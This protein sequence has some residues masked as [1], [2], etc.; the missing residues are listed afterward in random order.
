MCWPNS[1][2]TFPADTVGQV[3]LGWGTGCCGPCR[4]TCLNV[5]RPP[6]RAQG[7]GRGSYPGWARAGA[8]RFSRQG[9]RAGRGLLSRRICPLLLG[10]PSPALSPA[11]SFLQPEKRK[12]SQ[13][14]LQC[15][16]CFGTGLT[17]RSE[18]S[19]A[20]SKHPSLR[21]TVNRKLRVHLLLWRKMSLEVPDTGPHFVSSGY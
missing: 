5:G 9:E 14:R 6:A 17:T 7:E 2:P 11:P 12:G 19:L 13:S 15:E 20:Q 18:P 10:R 1:L 4:Y 8:G 16:G 21:G 3:W